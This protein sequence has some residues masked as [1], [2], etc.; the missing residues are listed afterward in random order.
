MG[1]QQR[2]PK[3]E[4]LLIYNSIIFVNLG[5]HSRGRPEEN[6]YIY[7]YREKLSL[8]SWIIFLQVSQFITSC[9]LSSYKFDISSQFYVTN[10]CRKKPGNVNFSYKELV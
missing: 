1:K 7:L 9:K 6:V 3:V 4:V 2:I 5:V 8:I 10:F